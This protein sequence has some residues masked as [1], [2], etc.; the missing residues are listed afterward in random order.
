MKRRSLFC[1]R[2]LVSPQIAQQW[3]VNLTLEKGKKI[4]FTTSTVGEIAEQARRDII[5][6][7]ALCC[8]RC[9]QHKKLANSFHRDTTEKKWFF[10]SL[11]Q[12][13]RWSC[14]SV[15]RT[16]LPS[17]LS[18][19][20]KAVGNF[21]FIAPRVI[22]L[23]LSKLLNQNPSKSLPNKLW[24]RQNTS[25][26]FFRFEYYNF[27]LADTLTRRNWPSWGTAAEL[28]NWEFQNVTGLANE[29]NKAS[30]VSPFLWTAK[31]HYPCFMTPDPFSAWTEVF[32]EFQKNSACCRLSKDRNETG[33]DDQT[34]GKIV[35]TTHSV[36]FNLS[37]I[38]SLQHS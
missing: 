1:E 7:Q 6:A 28:A 31:N 30:F 17:R 15:H 27:Q 2:A 38:V 8:R 16:N 20:E 9:W 18:E 3:I 19:G 37:F 22:N 35:K 33:G 25:I 14:F 32:W 4:C 13:C 12:R 23:V 36:S 10:F 21:Q 26:S 34:K 29:C 11:L 5:G 24:T